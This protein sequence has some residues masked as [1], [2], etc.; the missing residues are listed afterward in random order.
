MIDEKNEQDCWLLIWDN[1][2]KIHPIYLQIILDST[3]IILQNDTI[4]TSLIAATSDISFSLTITLQ[5]YIKYNDIEYFKFKNDA[6]SIRNFQSEFDEN[7]KYFGLK[8]ESDWINIMS[9][10]SRFI[11]KKEEY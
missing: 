7:L 4:F 5:Y 8:R 1:N 6:E 10:L 9:R 3:D 11:I 2:R